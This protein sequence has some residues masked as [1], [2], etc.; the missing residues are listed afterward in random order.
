LRISERG[1][2]QV[3]LI[4]KSI[5]IF[6]V[7][8]FISSSAFA[9]GD[10]NMADKIV[11]YQG[12]CHSAN[13]MFWDKDSKE[14]KT[15]HISSSDTIRQITDLLDK[16]PVSGDIMI[17]MGPTNVI[18]LTLDCD[19]SKYEIHF[20]GS[21]IKTPATSFYAGERPEEK[22]LFKLLKAID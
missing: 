1:W 17:S 5:V 20:Y 3:V 11:W 12:N 7:S 19:K 10:K 16:L 21:R 22:A 4:S 14:T 18:T 6:F 15:K 2:G 13:V 9:I 8:F